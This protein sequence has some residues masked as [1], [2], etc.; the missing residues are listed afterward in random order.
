LG[1][2]EEHVHERADERRHE[3]DQR[4]ERD[5]ERVGDATP[6]VLEH[7]EADGEPEDDSDRDQARA[8][9]RP[10]TGVEEV[11]RQHG[12]HGRRRH[13]N[14][15]LPIKY[16]A[17]NASPT[18]STSAIATN[19]KTLRRG[20]RWATGPRAGRATRSRG[21]APPADGPGRGPSRGSPRPRR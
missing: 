19:R 4:A 1:R 7:P 21:P 11:G 20:P 16:P 9:V 3:T 8:R 5:E 17:V 10:R 15:S 6:R 13:Y 14:S 18:K 12:R 2:A